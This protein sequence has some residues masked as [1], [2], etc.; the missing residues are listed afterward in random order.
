MPQNSPLQQLGLCRLYASIITSII[1]S[2]VITCAG[3]VLVLLRPSFVMTTSCFSSSLAVTVDSNESKYSP[4]EDDGSIHEDSSESG[5]VIS[6]LER[7]KDPKKLD[8]TRKQKIAQNSLHDGRQRK[9]PLSSCNP[10]SVSLVQ[11]AREFPDEHL[12]FSAA[13]CER[14]FSLL[15]ASFG[16]QQDMTLQDY[17]QTSV[18][19]Q[20]NTRRKLRIHNLYI[21]MIKF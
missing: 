9:H 10:K 13:A 21:K 8:L 2:C 18:M 4:F 6:F 5:S 7:L 19:L 17:I 14:A 20:F 12:C 3:V 15:K 1:G 11:R 16:P